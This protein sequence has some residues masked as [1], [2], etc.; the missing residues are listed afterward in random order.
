[1]VDRCTIW[2]IVLSMFYVNGVALAQ[3]SYRTDSIIA[4]QKTLGDAWFNEHID[5]AVKIGDQVPDFDLR[6]G[7]N[8]PAGIRKL[9]DLRGKLVIL[10]FWSLG[11]AS[12]I[13][14]FPHM[15]ELQ[16]E[17][18]DQLQIILVNTRESQAQIDQTIAKW[19]KLNVLPPDL[20][21]LSGPRED[22]VNLFPWRVVPHHV[23]IDRAGVLRVTGTS[24]NTQASKITEL[25]A[26]RPVISLGSAN[27]SPVFD[28]QRPYYS[29]LGASPLKAT[30]TS[31]L[32]TFNPHY[33]GAYGGWIRQ[34]ID[35]LHGTLR[36]TYI[37]IELAQLYNDVF[38]I[39]I[40]RDENDHYLWSPNAQLYG[41]SKFDELLFLVSDT[42]R[43]TS[44]FKD[45]QLTTDEELIRSRWC[46]EQLC[47]VGMLLKEQATRMLANLNQ[48]FGKLYGVRGTIE[49]RKVSCYVILRTTHYKRLPFR[50]AKKG[51]YGPVTKDGR[52]YFRYSDFPFHLTLRSLISGAAKHG[53]ASFVLNETGYDGLVTMDLPLPTSIQT[54][55]DI[56]RAIKPY[57]LDI[58]PAERVLD[59]L[60][61]REPGYQ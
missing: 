38:T 2:W 50:S 4:W 11:C 28:R 57:G 46:Y 12:C 3:T 59:F 58:Q 7:R 20:P 36:N 53:F 17:F 40:G 19:G 10:D 29:L 39:A 42:L 49:K 27:N 32:T 9:S 37:N 25:L 15:V 48:Q 54:V 8:L 24:N 1:M 23:W 14:A 30:D 60:V 43:Y 22:L 18:K 5:G 47:P 55:E 56:R 16:K 6:P 31:F 21:I 13:E 26:S 44:R 34:V 41:S 52:A 33:G 61:L 35:T 45:W 51:T